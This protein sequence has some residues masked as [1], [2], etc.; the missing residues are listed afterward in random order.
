MA[1]SNLPMKTKSTSPS[2]TAESAPKIDPAFL[3]KARVLIKKIKAKLSELEKGAKKPAT[4]K[5]QPAK[6][7]PAAKA[8]AKPAPKAKARSK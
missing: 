5:K 8:A 3:P 7:A 1:K 4:K 6:K 2:S